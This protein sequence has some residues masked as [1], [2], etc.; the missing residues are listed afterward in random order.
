MRAINGKLFLFYVAFAIFGYALVAPLADFFAMGAGNFSVAIQYRAVML[1]AAIAFIFKSIVID[2]KMYLD[3]SGKQGF[4]LLLFFWV[5]ITGRLFYDGI[6]QQ[7]ALGEDTLSRLAITGYVFVFIPLISLARLYNETDLSYIFQISFYI[8]LLGVSFAL[9]SVGFALL[10]GDWLGG[11]RFSLE[12]LNPVSLGGYSGALFILSFGLRSLKGKYTLLLDIGMIIG[13][14]GVVLSGSRG[15]LISLVAVLFLMISSR[16]S[17]KTVLVSSICLPIFVWISLWL[18]S[19][20]LPDFDVFANYLAI[21]SDRDQSAQIRFQLY[22]GALQQFYNNPIF[23]DL[24]VEREHKYYPHNQVLEILMAT[25]IF[26]F[27]AFLI[28][29]IS[30]IFKLRDMLKGFKIQLTMARIFLYLLV[31]YIT[32]GA[33]SGSIV[34]SVEYWLLSTLILFTSFNKAYYMKTA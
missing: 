5:I 1:G 31:F 2:K 19:L 34:S 4:L 18:S 13:F 8:L 15:A 23:G 17:V 9:F 26:G 7:D 27:C 28:L 3:R 30:V 32:A 20:F 24:I 29:S 33:F 22:E 14:S 16:F 10:N 12:G 21:G 25:G 6:F 11:S